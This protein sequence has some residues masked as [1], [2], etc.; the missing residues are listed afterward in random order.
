MIFKVRLFSNLLVI[1]KKMLPKCRLKILK[2]AKHQIQLVK[3]KPSLVALK[4]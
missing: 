4:T 1:N 3:T 2:K